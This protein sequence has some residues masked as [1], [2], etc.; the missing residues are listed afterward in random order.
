MAPIM[1]TQ[2][3]FDRA[4]ILIRGTLILTT[5]ISKKTKSILA[6]VVMVKHN[7]STP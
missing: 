1:E 6:M 5:T 4:S 3:I 7:Q 2:P